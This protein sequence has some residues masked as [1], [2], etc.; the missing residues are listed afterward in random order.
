MDPLKVAAQFV[1]YTRYSGRENQQGDAA[2]AARFAR[3]NWVAFLPYA[4]EGL[5]RLLIR[6]AQPGR[7]ATKA[8]RVLYQ[9]KSS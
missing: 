5:G 4:H 2:D 1:A 7:S 3:E 6:L 8:E 9:S